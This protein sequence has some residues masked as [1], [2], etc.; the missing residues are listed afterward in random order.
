[1]NGWL[2]VRIVCHVVYEP[3]CKAV[4]YGNCYKRFLWQGQHWK[5]GI[6]AS[7]LR[8]AL[9]A[10]AMNGME[11]TNRAVYI[12]DCF[13]R[14]LTR[15]T[16][17]FGSCT[18]LLL[19]RAGPEYYLTWK[20]HHS[21][22]VSSGHQLDYQSTIITACVDGQ[23]IPWCIIV[24]QCDS[25]RVLYSQQRKSVIA[26]YRPICGGSWCAEKARE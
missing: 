24:G 10:G 21:T 14:V 19:N 25:T 11:L 26:L 20:Y 2:Y 13:V 1:M 15:G 6:T 18:R 17:S 7:C 3:F 16:L 12:P 9:L 5:E 22:R 8:D 4:C 23:S